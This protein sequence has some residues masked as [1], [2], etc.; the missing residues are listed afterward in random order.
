MDKPTITAKDPISDG[1][2]ATPSIVLQRHFDAAQNSSDVNKDTISMDLNRSSVHSF[3]APLGSVD[4]PPE[5]IHDKLAVDS[6]EPTED[7]APSA[8]LQVHPGKDD[9]SSI[10]EVDSAAAIRHKPWTSRHTGSRVDDSDGKTPSTRTRA[11]QRSDAEEKVQAWLEHTDIS[12]PQTT[13]QDD[14]AEHQPQYRRKS[15]I[16]AL[17]SH[18]LHGKLAGLGKWINKNDPNYNDS[19]PPSGK[20]ELE[21]LNNSN[22]GAIGFGK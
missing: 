2:I 14:D 1:K 15:T 21:I 3:G 20:Q 5:S 4:T 22:D 17:K 7:Y 10:S 13:P 19:Q 6:L 9:E 11:R 8:S 12:D 18:I 16:Q